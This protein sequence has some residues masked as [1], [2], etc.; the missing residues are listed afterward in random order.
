M[1]LTKVFT[2]MDIKNCKRKRGPKLTSLVTI[3]IDD[4]QKAWLEK[5]E[6]SPTLLFREALKKYGYK[7]KEGG[8]VDERRI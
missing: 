3:R 5:N 8:C 4:Q 7:T 6:V 1:V 2:K